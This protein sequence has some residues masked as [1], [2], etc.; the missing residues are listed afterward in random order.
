[1]ARTRREYRISEWERFR[2]RSPDRVRR[3]NTE[4]NQKHYN[5]DGTSG[6]NENQAR[7]AYYR[8]VMNKE[9]EILNGC[10]PLSIPDRHYP[11]SFF[12]KRKTDG[13]VE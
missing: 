1:M 11:K 2:R 10:V 9:E 7:L 13:E 12:I 6:K 8:D 4:T 5:Y 3:S